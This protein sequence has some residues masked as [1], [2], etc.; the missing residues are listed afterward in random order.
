MARSAGARQLRRAPSARR[1]AGAC[2]SDGRA[3]KRGVR[4]AAGGRAQ[5]DGSTGGANA[6]ATRLRAPRSESQDRQED[7][8]RQARIA[9]EA[10]RNGSATDDA[11]PWSDRDR[12][13]VRGAS[14]RQRAR[15]A[16]AAARLRHESRRDLSHAGPAADAPLRG[17]LPLAGVAARYGRVGRGRH[18]PRGQAR[19]AGVAA[20]QGRRPIGG[21]LSRCPARRSAADLSVHRQRSRRGESG[22]AA[23][24][25]G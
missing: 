21:V 14:T 9:S 8:R 18:R 17:V 4:A 15:R 6:A 24:A 16:A 11:E 25:R 12:L 7:H 10:Q 23:R 3:I 13:P 20:G 19:H 2:G 22:Q 1:V 5:P